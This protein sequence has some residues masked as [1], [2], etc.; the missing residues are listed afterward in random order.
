MSLPLHHCQVK[1]FHGTVAF[2]DPVINSKSRVAKA[3]VEAL[4]TQMKLKPEMFV[5]GKLEAILPE[6]EQALVVP[7]SAV[8]W[9]GTLTCLC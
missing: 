5:S 1:L 7:K 9:T 8:M 6:R 4:N 3:R 2:I